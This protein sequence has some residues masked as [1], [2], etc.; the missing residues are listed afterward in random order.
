VPSSVT[1]GEIQQW[2]ADYK[3]ELAKA[4]ARV[5]ELEEQ[6]AKLRAALEEIARYDRDSPHGP[7][8]CRYGCDT[9]HIAQTA[10]AETKGTK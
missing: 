7:G 3:T 9:P 10:L 6:N 2:E 1:A 4:E 8:V 5:E